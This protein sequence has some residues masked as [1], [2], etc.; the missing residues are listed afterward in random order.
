MPS[1]IS[2]LTHCGRGAR[3]SPQQ[4]L[5]CGMS[6]GESYPMRWRP[7]M[8]W[9]SDP[10]GIWRRARIV[11][12]LVTGTS[13]CLAL[14]AC[15]PL[16][17]C[18]IFGGC[19]EQQQPIPFQFGII[20]HVLDATT[21]RGV[22]NA[23]VLA[24]TDDYHTYL[25]NDG[26]FEYDGADRAGIYRLTISAPGYAT[27]TVQDVEVKPDPVIGGLIPATVTVKLQRLQ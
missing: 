23:S 10:A 26:G 19:T 2:E 12:G 5:R 27:A 14:A 11:L 18:L 24:E 16:T 13:L 21:Q 3:S 6:H 22:T 25:T 1:M 17:N 9:R 4:L 7:I 15:E 8:N 20:C